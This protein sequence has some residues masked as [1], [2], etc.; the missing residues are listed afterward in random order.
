MTDDQLAAIGRLDTLFTSAGIAYWL[1]GGWAVD[2]HAGRITREHADIDVAVWQA[3]VGQVRTLLAFDG[4]AESSPPDADGYESYSNAR[5]RLDL[6]FLAR[7]GQGS[8][9][10]PL[11]SGRGEWPPDSFPGDVRVLAGTSAHVVSRASLIADKSNVREDL[12]TASKD[13]A[14]RRVL[15]GV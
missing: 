7:D 5:L 12:A 6:A 10:T 15:R 14:D 8:V 13:A 9:Y 3:D 2:F 1:F 4:W 11:A